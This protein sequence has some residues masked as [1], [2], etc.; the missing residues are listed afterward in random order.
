M[1]P[2]R[3]IL[4]G[5][6]DAGIVADSSCREGTCATCERVVV[7]GIPDHRDSVL[8]ETER[9]ANETIVICG[10]RSFSGRLALEL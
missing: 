10:S 9:Q 8:S 2:D 7:S 3:S 4:D 6:E 1:P 5:V